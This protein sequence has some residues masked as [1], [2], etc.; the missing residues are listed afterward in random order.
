M[1]WLQPR[2]SGRPGQRDGR[3]D[4]LGGDRQLGRDGRLGGLEE[5]RHGLRRRGGRGRDGGLPSPRQVKP[6]GVEPDRRRP[7]S[8][9]GVV[10]GLH[11]GGRGGADVGLLL[12]ADCAESPARLE[13]R[14]RSMAA[15]TSG[16]WSPAP[17]D[18]RLTTVPC[19]GAGGACRMTAGGSGGRGVGLG[20]C[21]HFRRG[22]PGVSTALSAGDPGPLKK[23]RHPEQRQGAPMRPTYVDALMVSSLF[24]G[25]TL[26][27]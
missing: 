14:S 26:V 1:M 19:G 4:G 21:R 5:R 22:R 12:Q 11:R 20:A 10:V 23:Q 15:G 6:P 3:R 27:L 13:V 25:P 16:C 7:V 8:P 2:W 17:T 24:L 18:R 9:R